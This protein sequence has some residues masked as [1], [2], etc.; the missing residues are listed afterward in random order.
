[1]WYWARYLGHRAIRGQLT[2]AFDAWQQVQATSTA[3]CC[4]AGCLLS[5]DRPTVAEG[6]WTMDIPR[7]SGELTVV[8][9]AIGSIPATVVDAPMGL[10]DDALRRSAP[11]VP[12][13][14]AL[15]QEFVTA[16]EQLGR[17]AH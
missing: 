14:L 8:L 6:R 10:D 3:L 12:S 13:C 16:S 11:G 15:L 2:T 5:C 1:M 7:D 17:V 4:M 9:D